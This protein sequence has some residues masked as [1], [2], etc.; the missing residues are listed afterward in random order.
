M[1]HACQIMRE[2]HHK[3]MASLGIPETATDCDSKD[4]SNDTKPLLPMIVPPTK[5]LMRHTNFLQD[6]VQWQHQVLPDRYTNELQTLSPLPDALE[7][8]GGSEHPIGGSIPVPSSETVQAQFCIAMP[9]VA[10]NVSSVDITN[11]QQTFNGATHSHNAFAGVYVFQLG[12]SELAESLQAHHESIVNHW[13]TWPQHESAP[14]G[15]Q[16]VLAGSVENSVKWRQSLPG[17]YDEPE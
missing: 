13:T 11:H 14:G 3:T 10:R 8:E 4:H 17:G 6:I 2:E 9:T 16:V 5:V 1:R 12:R 7:S 15:V